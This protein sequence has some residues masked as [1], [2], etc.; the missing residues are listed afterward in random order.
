MPSIHRCASAKRRNQL[1]P[2]ERAVLSAKVVLAVHEGRMDEEAAGV[3]LRR[4]MGVQ[5]TFLTALQ[6]LSGQE[7]ITSLQSLP[8]DWEVEGLTKGLAAQAVLLAGHICAFAHP[9]GAVLSAG[10]LVAALRRLPLDRA[11]TGSQTL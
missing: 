5:W 8:E 11:G 9:G 3:L 4:A 7:A 6:Y 1:P 2:V 10:H